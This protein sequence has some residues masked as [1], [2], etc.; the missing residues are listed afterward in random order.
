MTR[1]FPLTTFEEFL[2]W[3]DRPAY[4]CSCF[5]RLQFFGRLMRPAL[6]SALQ[7]TLERHVL[8]RSRIEQR[9][10]RLNWVPDEEPQP[11]ITWST[12]P[13]GGPMPTAT[14]LDLT[15]EI[16]LRLAIVES[17]DETTS[18]LTLQFH[19]ACCDGAGIFNF[20]NDLLISYALETGESSDRVRLPDLE[21][22]RL[23]QRGDYGLS[24][25][26]FIKIFRK[27]LIGLQGAWQ[28]LRRA[29][30]PL[31]PHE[32]HS[33]NAPPPEQYPAIVSHRFDADETQAMRDVAKRQQATLNDLLAR[34]IFLAMADL[35]RESLVP[36]SA[37]SASGS[38]NEWLRMMVPMNLRSK[39]DRLLPAANVVS[40]VFLDRRG[41]Q[42]D[43]PQK[44]LQ[45]IHD[46][47]QLIRD[48][49]L[50]L[51]FIFGLKISKLLPGGLRKA[52]RKN[53]CTTTCIF[54][55]L[56]KPLLRCRLP[57]QDQRLVAGNVVLD[58]MKLL[59]PICP[60]N[61]VTFAANHYAD[62]LSIT[63]HYDPRA[64]S[65]AVA[66]ML[67]DKFVQHCKNSASGGAPIP[68]LNGT[69]VAN[70]PR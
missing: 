63:L 28:F 61:C 69:A 38:E 17:P 44:L 22:Q 29:P 9:G 50:G 48:N 56:G 49:Q 39:D 55:N 67:L 7:T 11:R 68:V 26:G 14:H 4:P 30:T 70:V 20:I 42:C 33:H 8:L 41:K 3:Q 65:A 36:D 21:P 16:G 37:S 19:H 58:D 10:R 60:Y 43:R 32:V 59:A 52:A 53:K 27:Q 57:K 66:Q 5:I 35:R 47:M 2:Y 25:T 51:T 64:I 24:A 23:A 62:R 54:T 1:S 46:E 13:T 12:G 45:S 31:L 15:K 34:D 6:E 40:S 18:A